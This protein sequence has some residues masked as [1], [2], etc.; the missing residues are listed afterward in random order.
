MK[1]K[2]LKMLAE[3]MRAELDLLKHSQ[4]LKNKLVNEY[5]WDPMR[6]FELIDI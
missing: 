1:E 3:M 4:N 2:H 6:C 5:N